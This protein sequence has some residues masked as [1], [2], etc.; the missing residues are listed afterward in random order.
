METRRKMFILKII[1]YA[2][3]LVCAAIAISL[4]V[5]VTWDVMVEIFNSKSLAPKNDVKK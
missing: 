2:Y 5:S 3:A 1:W 4:A